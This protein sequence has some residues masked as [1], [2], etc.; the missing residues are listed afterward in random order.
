M[1]RP[2]P[3]FWRSLL[4]NDVVHGHV[5]PKPTDEPEVRKHLETAL[6]S[7]WPLVEVSGIQFL[8]GVFQLR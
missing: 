2:L 8:C 6:G 3:T 5:L 4:L 1:T 7:G